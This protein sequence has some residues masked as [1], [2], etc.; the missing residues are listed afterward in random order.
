MPVDI[1]FSED[2]KY[3]VYTFTEP[4]SIDELMEGYQQEKAY[5]DSVDN[6][7]HSIVDMSPLKRIPRNWLTAKRGPGLTHPRSGKILFVGISSG[8]QIIVR[9]ILRI[10]R[11]N[12][13]EFYNTREEAQARME[14]LLQETASSENSP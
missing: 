5:R 2:K 13:M 12:R 11:F 8:I 1:Q 9:T 4:L 14:E 6:T 10:A 3:I 7:V